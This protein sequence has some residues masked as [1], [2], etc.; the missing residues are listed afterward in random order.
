MIKSLNSI[1]AVVTDTASAQIAARASGFCLNH[2]RMVSP[3]GTAPVPLR[4]RACPRYI[5][6]QVHHHFAI[7]EHS[8]DETTG[9]RL[10]PIV[11]VDHQVIHK[12]VVPVAV[13][14]SY[15]KCTNA[16]I[17]N[18]LTVVQ[19]TGTLFFYSPAAV[20]AFAFF[21]GQAFRKAYKVVSKPPDKTFGTVS[22][23]RF[24]S[25]ITHHPNYRRVATRAS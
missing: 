4:F 9:A 20:A 19:L 8:T 2:H 11:S 10:L 13:L 16:F 14:P 6:T 23:K 17:P 7:E 25:T 3:S 21:V 15:E 18:K 24:A 5:G 1:S 22:A 12:L